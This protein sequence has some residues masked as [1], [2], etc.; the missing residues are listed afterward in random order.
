[1]RAGRRRRPL[2]RAHQRRV[3]PLSGL[4]FCAR[5]ETRLRAEANQKGIRY[6]RDPR[7]PTRVCD[8]RMVRAEEAEAAV[9][10]YL[11]AI[12][13]PEDWRQ[14]ILKLARADAT[15]AERVAARKVNLEGRLQRAKNLYLMGDLSEPEYRALRKD[16]KGKLSGL[17]VVVAPDLDDATFLAEDMGTLLRQAT[18]SELKEVFN[19]LL[20]AVYLDSGEAGPVVAISPKP[21]VRHLM[22]LSTDDESIG[23]NGNLKM[24]PGLAR[25]EAGPVSLCEQD[26]HLSPSP[27]TPEPTC[28]P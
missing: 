12:R 15:D 7:R 6:Y 20:D 28:I 4:A 25:F 14:R 1:V 2:G 17:E 23:K 21:F 5:C 3:Y 24:P 8:Q 10:E 22:D 9:V 18:P 13:L 16:I 19:A 11:S 26:A 27:P